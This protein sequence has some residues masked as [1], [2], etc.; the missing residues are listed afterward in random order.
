[1]PADEREEWL[2]HLDAGR[3]TPNMK[4]AFFLAAASNDFFG[5]PD[6]VQATL[7]SITGEKNHVFAPNANHKI[8]VPGGSTFD[9]KPAVPFTPTPF[10]PYPTPSGGKANWLAMEAPYFEFYLKGIGHP[11]PKVNVQKTGDPHL[12]RFDIN[13]PLPLTEVKVYW[14]KASPTVSTQ[15]D[16]KK[17]EWLELPTRKTAETSYEANLPAEA[18]DWFALVTDER[19]VTVSGDL[20]HLAT[21]AK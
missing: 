5:Y 1:M 7:N 2:N 19:P 9:N 8:P 18:A 13:A 20:V 6:S 11:F 21:P 16:V 10:Q 14:A 12:A 17:R 15:E 3:R 4:A